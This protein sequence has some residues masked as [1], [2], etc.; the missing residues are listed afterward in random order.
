M[1]RLRLGSAYGFVRESKGEEKED[2]W[3]K[4]EKE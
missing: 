2:E 1:H 4:Q 3:G